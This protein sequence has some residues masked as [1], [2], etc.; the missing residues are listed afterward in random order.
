MTKEMVKNDYKK[1]VK[2]YKNRGKINK[3]N[4]KK[5]YNIVNID[6]DTSI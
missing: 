6:L 3:K 5:N 1:K 4:C 2:N